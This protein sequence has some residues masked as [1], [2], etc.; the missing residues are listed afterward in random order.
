MITIFEEPK[1]SS[2]GNM[3][4][5]EVFA[6]SKSGY[7]CKF[8]FEWSDNDTYNCVFDSLTKE[9]AMKILEIVDNANI[10]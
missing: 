5:T 10:N 2:I 9:Q 4:P 3:I 1:R 6:Q 7:V 8:I